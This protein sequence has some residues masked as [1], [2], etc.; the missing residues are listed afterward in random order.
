MDLI[1]TQ[2]YSPHNESMMNQLKEMQPL[3]YRNLTK[4]L[5]KIIIILLGE[6]KYE[7][8]QSLN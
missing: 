6:K 4:R 7:S 3:H 1:T 5:F 2:V 8:H